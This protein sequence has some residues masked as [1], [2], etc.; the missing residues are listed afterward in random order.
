M[1]DETL[2]VLLE[3]TE[4]E[5]PVI[6]R[7]RFSW[8][9]VGFALAGAAV[10]GL[11]ALVVLVVVPAIRAGRED[12]RSP[13]EAL[14]A[15]AGLGEDE[16]EEGGERW[17]RLF[18]LDGKPS[19]TGPDIIGGEAGIPAEET[20]GLLAPEPE[21]VMPLGKA[22]GKCGYESEEP[23]PETAGYRLV[24][25]TMGTYGSLYALLQ[26][27]GVGPNAIAEVTSALEKVTDPKAVRAEDGFRLY[28]DEK[29]GKLKFL[30][31]KRSDTKIYHVLAFDSGTV[32]AHKVTVPTER[33]WVKAGGVV[34]GSLFASAQEAGLEGAIVNHFMAVFGAYAKFGTDTREGD[35]FRVIVSGEWLG[36]QF[37]DYDPPQILEYNGQKTGRLLAIYYESSPGKGQYYWP[38]GTSL[39]RLV[40]DVPLEVLRVTSH[41]D[42]KRMHPVLKVR[43]PH[44][45]TDFGAPSGTPV[46][47]FDAGTVKKFGMKGAM[48]N[49]VQIDHGGGIS[50][51]YG[52]L[53]GFAKGMKAGLK[54]KKGQTIGFV[55][56]T[57]RST[58]PHLHFGLKKG[59]AFVDPMKYLKVTTIKEKPIDKSLAEG[60]EK[61]AK[62]L[63]LMLKAIKVPDL[64][65]KA[66]AKKTQ[67]S[68]DE[69]KSKGKK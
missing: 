60:F 6:T 64:P 62:T 63:H 61:R 55:G 30:E 3:E 21:A 13:M 57:G 19:P 47:A 25:G 28:I 15:S 58:G 56:N 23:G 52:H 36:K 22:E 29:S 46:F 26:K 17:D 2:D 44:L 9:W 10:A 37:L 4:D 1:R 42:P 41:F 54:V 51:Y 50:T 7:S 49:M 12:G 20:D 11:A 32:D 24:H 39:K 35:T 53:S 31:L 59:K 16:K 67:G 33:R 27:N 48:G 34:K 5:V 8:R 40:A 18:E 69:T 14:R 43:K 65:G 38:D 68:P 45:G 66:V